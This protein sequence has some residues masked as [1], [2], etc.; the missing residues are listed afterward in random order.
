MDHV[1]LALVAVADAGTGGG[2]QLQQAVDLAA[3]AIGGKSGG[4]G[5]Q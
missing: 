3:G 4:Q 2:Q 1:V 5:G